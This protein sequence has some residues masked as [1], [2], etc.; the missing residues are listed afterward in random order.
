MLGLISGYAVLYILFYS[1]YY[2]WAD[3]HY[4][5]KLFR[6][7]LTIGFLF[8]VLFIVVGTFVLNRV[9]NQSELSF[10]NNLIK[11]MGSPI[12][13]IGRAHV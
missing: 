13:E 11:Y 3:S 1:R 10:L 7:L 5:R 2:A 9:D 8:I 6:A 12:Q 4:S